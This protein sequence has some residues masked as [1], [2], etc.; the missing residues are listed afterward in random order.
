MTMMTHQRLGQNLDI[1]CNLMP[2]K[3]EKK[4]RGIPPIPHNPIGV[5]WLVSQ[6]IF[7]H[8]LGSFFVNS[9]VTNLRLS[10]TT[11]VALYPP[12]YPPVEDFQHH[13]S[14]SETTPFRRL[15]YETPSP[16]ITATSA[17]FHGTAL[18][19]LS[20]NKGS[21]PFFSHFAHTLKSVV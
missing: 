15:I 16:T 8:S 14:A 17:A 18:T 1:F 20:E 2:K 9:A 3:P 7:E 6:A 10:G 12:S 21:P 4:V 11:R 5:S 19:T 13:L